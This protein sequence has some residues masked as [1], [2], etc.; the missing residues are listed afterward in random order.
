MFV[1]QPN[2]HDTALCHFVHDKTQKVCKTP[3]RNLEIMY[4]GKLSQTVMFENCQRYCE[5]TKFSR[6]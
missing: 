2:F 5:K 3:S 1:R 4:K 6:N